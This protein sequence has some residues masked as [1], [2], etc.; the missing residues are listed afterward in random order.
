M[1]E[2]GRIQLTNMSQASTEIFLDDSGWSPDVLGTLAAMEHEVETLRRRERRQ[3]EALARLTEQVA[4]AAQMQR[5]LLA[6]C[7]PA[8]EGAEFHAFYRPAEAVGGD[9]YDI[10]RIDRTRLALVIGDATGHGLAAGMLSALVKGTLGRRRQKLA[11]ER[12]ID[13]SEV[14]AAINHEL[15]DCALCEC[16]FVTAV[17]ATYDEASR[18][19]TW[20]R[21]GAPYP[22][23]VRPGR[24][25]RQCRS[26]GLAL[27]VHEDAQ[28][29]KMELRL[30]PGDTVLFYSDGLDALLAG[31]TALSSSSDATWTDWFDDLPRNGA[32]AQLDALDKRIERLDGRGWQ[33][34]DV[35]A[36]TLHIRE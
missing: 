9:F 5:R 19:L 21:G 35:T 26:E 10:L 25:A 27:G 33:V 20:A 3:T 24:S 36:V 18:V 13:P 12:A 31:N 30:E 4:E 17:Y 1:E 7:I 2:V 6:S 8:V 14:L 16:E 22:V 34:D 23:I 29:E 11:I 28:F 32:K 15:L